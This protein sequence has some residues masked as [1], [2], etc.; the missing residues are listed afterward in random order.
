MNARDRRGARVR[1][2]SQARAARP[3]P[4]HE[5]QGLDSC[6]RLP[7]AGA[8]FLPAPE[9]FGGTHPG[10]AAA[11]LRSA[12]PVWSPHDSLP[13]VSGLVTVSP[14]LLLLLSPV[15]SELCGLA[16]LPSGSEP[17]S[18]LLSLDCGYRQA[19][20][21]GC[22]EQKPPPPRPCSG[23]CWERL[24]CVHLTPTNTTADPR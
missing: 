17:R 8:D 4:V 14:W 24:A 18:S 22:A 1:L 7:P 11:A 20:G 5:P 15:P 2:G 12:P 6:S 13:A 16:E 3:E 9:Q 23:H 10:G 19:S 21:A